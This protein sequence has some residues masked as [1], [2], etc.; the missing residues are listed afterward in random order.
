MRRVINTLFRA[1]DKELE[2]QTLDKLVQPPKV[3]F[4]ARSQV[5]FDPFPDEIVIDLNKIIIIYRTFFQSHKIVSIPLHNLTNVTCSVNVLNG[6]LK[7]EIFGELHQ[8]EPIRYL[9]RSDALRA[10]KIING[11]VICYRN[12]IDLSP[13]DTQNIVRKLM[14]IGRV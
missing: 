1:S 8:P 11:L 3:L 5:L 12:R 9:S 6:T 13:Y 7:F 10:E 14:E 2:Y 4:R